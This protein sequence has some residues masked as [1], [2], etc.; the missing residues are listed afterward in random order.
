LTEVERSLHYAGDQGSGPKPAAL[1]SRRFS[2]LVAVVV[3]ELKRA[4]T[5][6]DL[7]AKFSLR[8]GHPQYPVF[9]GFGFVISGPRGGLVLIGSSSD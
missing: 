9:W 6:A 5:A 3:D 8:E 1:R 7:L 4:I 2:E